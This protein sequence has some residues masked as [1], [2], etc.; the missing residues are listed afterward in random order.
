MGQSFEAIYQQ[1]MADFRVEWAALSGKDSPALSGTVSFSS[2]YPALN[3]AAAVLFTA[4]GAALTEQSADCR[5][6]LDMPAEEVHP[7]GCR[8]AAAVFT[9]PLSEAER[10]CAPCVVETAPLYGAGLPEDCGVNAALLRG[11]NAPAMHVIDLFRLLLTLAAAP[12]IGCFRA[13]EVS[14]EAAPPFRYVPVFS[15]ESGIKTLRLL[16]EHPERR[17]YDDTAYAGRLRPLQQLQLK[18]LLELDRVC[19]ERN[20]LYFLAGGSLLGAIREGGFIPWD[21]DIDVCMDRPNFERLCAAA[22][23]AFGEEYFFQTYETDPSFCSPFGKLRLKDTRFSTPF[24]SQFSG[25]HNEIFIDI[26]IHDA[27]PK[28]P[29]L[30]RFHVFMTLF[31]RSMVFHKWGGTPMHFYGRLKLLCRVMTRV[32]RRRSMDQLKR[33]EHRVLTFWNKRGTGRLYDGT[34]DHLRNGSFPAEW[35][36]RCVEADFE[37]YRLPAPVGY[38]ADLRFLYG[39]RYRD[40]PLPAQRA[41]HHENV[42]FSLGPYGQPQ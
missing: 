10:A 9:H 6:W 7:E 14:A 16:Y 11:G 40:W 22:P 21:D 29:L 28:S 15:R 26:F 32:I 35:L 38:D 31:A 12:C 37:G 18:L 33:F 13:E 24:S 27:A 19:R 4:R 1:N 23:E 8:N 36:E 2:P 41:V 3:E 34:G 5:I 25:M 39:E 30:S 20:I 17:Y 42:D